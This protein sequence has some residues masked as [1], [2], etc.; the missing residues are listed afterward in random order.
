MSDNQKK[1]IVVIQKRKNDQRIERDL[2]TIGQ[3]CFLIFCPWVNLQLRKDTA[4]DGERE[5]LQ[6]C[7]LLS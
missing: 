2:Q 6:T 1:Y 7:G 3:G 4:R 5:T